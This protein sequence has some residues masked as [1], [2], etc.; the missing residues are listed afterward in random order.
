VAFRPHGGESIASSLA[1]QVGTLTSGP[2]AGPTGCG[3]R[4]SQYCR[5]VLDAVTIAREMNT[6]VLVASQPYV[7]DLHVQQQ[8]AM[9]Q[10][11]ERQFK[12]DKRVSYLDLGRAIDLRDQSLAFDGMHLTF[13]GNRMIADA[14]V[15]PVLELLETAGQG[16]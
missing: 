4:W 9:R 12:A 11:L 6:L 1:S 3:K 2:A 7:S 13:T 15:Q 16:R 5:T 10:A 14:F 8:A